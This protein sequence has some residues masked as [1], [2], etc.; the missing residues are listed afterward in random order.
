MAN[1]EGPPSRH[2]ERRVICCG[3]GCCDA[4]RM[5]LP[6]V[7]KTTG[8][9][10]GRWHAAREGAINERTA[11]G[12]GCRRCEL[13]TAG[14]KQQQ[15]RPVSCCG[16]GRCGAARMLLPGVAKTTGGAGGQWYT[17]CEGANG[18]CPAILHA[19]LSHPAILRMPGLVVLAALES[20]LAYLLLLGGFV[21]AAPVRAHEGGVQTGVNVFQVATV[22]LTVLLVIWIMEHQAGNNR[23]KRG[24][25]Q[26]VQRGMS[27]TYAKKV[28]STSNA[29]WK[30]RRGCY[31]TETRRT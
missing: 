15:Q 20:R 2:S 31:K 18:Q 21:D 11:D 5:L 29:C 26:G 23:R 1:T 25:R 3:G 28:Q 7:A 17:V 30:E 27:R 8:G 16:G 4:A 13:W 22:L 24:N 19:P 12:S 6:G 10:G 14:V 9:A